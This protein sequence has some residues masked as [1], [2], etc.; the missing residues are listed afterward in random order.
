MGRRVTVVGG[1]P[2]GLMAAEVLATAGVRVVVREQMAS[3]GRKLL[4]AGRGGLN[5]TH[6]EDLDAFRKRYGA[7][8]PRLS[9]A[10]DAFTPTD[11]R[12]WCAGLGQEPFVGSS[13]RVFPEGFRATPLLR[14]WLQRLDVLGVEIR[15]RDRWQPWDATD[16]DAIVLALGGAS[17][18]RTG[19][20]GAWVD[21]FR[22]AGIGVS[23]LRP[24]NCGFVVD[25]T[26][27][28]RD[29][30]TGEPMKNVAL[31]FDGVV[32]R[33]DAIVAEDGLEAGPVYALSAALRDAIEQAGH[34]TLNVDLLPDVDAA[35]LVA[36]LARRR[37]KDSAS[38]WLRRAGLP[39]VS[40]GVLRESTENRLPGDPEQ[41]AALVKSVPL[42]L[43]ATRPIGRAISTA[44]GVALDAIDDAYMLR[45]RPGTFVAGEML[46]WE[47]PTGGYLLQATFSTAVAAA[48][49]ALA[50]LEK[51]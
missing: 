17:W 32:A 10:I 37:D 23:P 46:D 22:D 12:A 36:R 9:G 7:A 5:L 39:P 20:D 43:I 28:F 35:A 16:A 1:G 14:A 2:A 15:V 40:I 29:R 11:L 41:M 30:F 49:G 13:G 25:W 27:T 51:S 8:A 50:W 47:A 44:G 48:R 4:V 26:D 3:V 42:R 21:G 34:A 45:S 6:S 33:G 24:A 18:P 38:S 19:S 31:S